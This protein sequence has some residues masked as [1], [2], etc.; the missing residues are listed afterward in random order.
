MA[1]GKFRAESPTTSETPPVLVCWYLPNR[2]VDTS[3]HGEVIYNTALPIIPMSSSG[4]MP[5]LDAFFYIV[6]QIITTS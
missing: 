5:L 4:D 2:V 6:V 3:P 1:A